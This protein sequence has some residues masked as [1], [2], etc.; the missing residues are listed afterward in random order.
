MKEFTKLGLLLLMIYPVLGSCIIVYTYSAYSSVHLNPPQEPHILGFPN[1]WPVIII[2]SVASIIVIIGGLCVLAGWKEFGERHKRFIIYALVLFA[3]YFFV[4]IVFVNVFSSTI[5]NWIT[6]GQGQS[7][8]AY[9]RTEMTRSLINSLLT[10]SLF[11][12]IVVFSLY[13]LEN[14][15]GRFILL[16]VFAA[17]ILIPVVTYIGSS[18]VIGGWVS[19]GLIDSQNQTT[20][21]LNFDLI[22]VSVW[23]GTTGILLL[24]LYLLQFVA[25]FIALYIPYRRIATGALSHPIVGML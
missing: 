2:G 3:V 9:L 23:T 1:L 21:S 17:A 18:M 13:H 16:V 15:K 8:A 4:V 11:G 7:T 22:P 25:L 12:L 6:A 20:T 5:A 19:Q 14:R 24:L 10:G